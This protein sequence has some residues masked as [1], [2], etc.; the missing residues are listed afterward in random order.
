M[1]P[2]VPPELLAVV[3][4]LLDVEGEPPVPPELLAAVV[5]VVV[6]ELLDVDGAP[7][8]PPELDV[9]LLELPLVLVLVLVPAPPPPVLCEGKNASVTAV[10]PRAG[11]MST[12][13]IPIGTTAPVL[14]RSVPSICA[15]VPRSWTRSPVKVAAP[16]E[17]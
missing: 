2:P 14:S 4:E 17:Q 3:D 11:L 12:P 15:A 8:V 1:A 13:R 9:V 6:D 16:A 10:V 5:V 7:P